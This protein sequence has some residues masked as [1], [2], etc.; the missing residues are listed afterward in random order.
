MAF[1]YS[2]P[3]QH[4]YPANYGTSQ[5][6]S[7]QAVQS[8]GYPGQGISPMSRLVSNRDEANATQEAL[9]ALRAEIEALKKPTGKAG[10]KND[11]DE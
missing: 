2:Y 1:N 7:M 4:Q 9:D 3:G 11:P 5:Q 6:P 8:G 10:K